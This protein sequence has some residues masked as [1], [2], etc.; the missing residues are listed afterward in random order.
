MGLEDMTREAEKGDVEERTDFKD[1]FIAGLVVGEG[2]FHVGVSRQYDE[3]SIPY[4]AYA[5]FK[6]NMGEYDSDVVEYLEDYFGVGNVNRVERDSENEVDVLRFKCSNI[7]EVQNHIIPF[8][9]EVFDRVP[10]NTDKYNSYMVWREIALSKKDGRSA[11]V[12]YLA[13]HTLMASYAKDKINQ[14][15]KGHS[16]TKYEEVREE[17]MD[18]YPSVVE[19]K[20]EEIKERVDKVVNQ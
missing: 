2:S 6:L 13:F 3:R 15:S 9:D 12:E 7:N 5:E 20:E 1:G 8:F 4:Y 16:H 11:S 19:E 17:I 14:R 18:K 10:V